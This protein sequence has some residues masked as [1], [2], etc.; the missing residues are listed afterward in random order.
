MA[1]TA[2]RQLLEEGHG[3]VL[4]CGPLLI[5]A[6]LGSQCPLKTLALLSKGCCWEQVTTCYVLLGGTPE[7]LGL[8]LGP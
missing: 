7:G 8:R 3:S 5:N 4:Q 1:G 6:I 2:Q